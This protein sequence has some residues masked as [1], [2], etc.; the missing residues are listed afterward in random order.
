MEELDIRDKNEL[1]QS[2]AIAN[3]FVTKNYLGQLTVHGILPMPKELEDTN[4]RDSIRVFRVGKIVY[5]R[6]ENAVEKL[7]SIYNAVESV[8]G[9]IIMLLESDGKEVQLYLGVR[10]PNNVNPSMAKDVLEKSFK[11]NFPGSGLENLTN[12]KIEG[13]LSKITTSPFDNTMRIVSSVSGIPSLKEDDKES[14]LQGMEKL[15][16]AM[17]GEIFSAILIADPLSLEQLA[18]IRTGYENLYSQ[19]V[20]FADS[21]LSFSENDSEAITEGVTKGFTSTVNESITNTQSHT[22]GKTTSTTRTENNSKTTSY[23]GVFATGAGIAG[24]L[25]AGPLGALVGGALGHGVSSLMGSRTS[26]TSISSVEG[27]N[28]SKTLGETSTSGTSEAKSIQENRGETITRGSSRNLQIKFQNKSVL[29]LLD[30]I[31]SQLERIK[32]CE[33]LGMWN[34][35]AYFIAN[36]PQTSVVAASTFKALMRGKDSFVEN[37]FINTWDNDNRVNLEEMHKYLSKLHHPLIDMKIENGLQLPYVTPGTLISGKELSIQMGLPVKSVKGLPVMEIETFGRDVISYNEE[38]SKSTIKRKLNIG[39]IYHMGQKEETN[40]DLDVDSLAMHTFITGSTGSGKSNTIYQI[41]DSL[42]RKQVKFLVIEPTKGEYKNIFGG[43]KDVH[44]FGTNPRFAPLLK[45]N[46]FSFP[47][48]IHVLEHIDRLVEIFNACWPMYAAMPAILKSAIETAYI[49]SGWDLDA[50]ICLYHEP[51]YPTFQDVMHALKEVIEMSSYSDELKGNYTGA[52]VTRLESLTNGLLGRMLAKEEVESS[53][54]FDENCIIDLSRVG[55][56]ET[57]SLLMGITFMK[58]QEYRMAEGRENSSLKHVTVLEEAHHLLRKTSSEQHQESSNLQGKAV[59]MIT[60]SIAEMRT[61]GEGFI[62][63][64][65]APGLLDQSVIRNTNTKIILRLPDEGDRE[66]VGRAAN[67]KEEQI[68]EISC[69]KVGVAAV[70]QNNWQQPVLSSI[71]CFDEKVS[72]EYKFNVE[73]VQ[74]QGKKIKSQLLQLILNGRITEERKIDLLEIDVMEL[75]NWLKDTSISGLEK[76]KL[77]K[78][79]EQYEKQGKMDLWQQ[80]NFE[81]LCRLMPEL[82]NIKQLMFFSK[83]TEDFEQW[84]SKLKEGLQNY[85]DFQGNDAYENALVQCLLR[86][87]ILQNPELE[88]AYFSWVEYIREADVV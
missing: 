35:A 21:Q 3:H 33:N 66:I 49:Q 86:E 81:S 55:S 2:F 67:L 20:P 59:E 56:I 30:K 7:A 83:N 79:L 15:I 9:T 88:N 34:C 62:I 36:D 44:V 19:L 64:D 84:T 53:V 31:D 76:E 4:I 6:K 52:L 80:D 29:N 60:N 78:N 10:V 5:D 68:K 8:G 65:Q 11:G 61:Y 43:R 77:L 48:E 69:L 37:A 51:I 85:V 22:M 58:L 28:E 1:E 45:I 14:F 26:G 13:L 73:E 47:D 38:S 54:L 82:L 72:F 70:Y 16:D 23:G 42:S 18:S 40:V 25:I 87:R 74:E 41:L 71:H 27:E 32:D 12:S 46:P 57:K 17:Q 75:K 24:G 50:S 63:A 39:K